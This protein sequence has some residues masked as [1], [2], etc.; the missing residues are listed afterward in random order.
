MLSKSSATTNSARFRLYSV[1]CTSMCQHC[2][3]CIR[4]AL[5]RD[6]LKHEGYQTE[7]LA[8]F[9][10]EKYGIVFFSPV[11]PIRLY[12]LRSMP[13]GIICFVF[14]TVVLAW[15]V[16]AAVIKYYTYPV[17]T[18][19]FYETAGQL[20]FPAV[21]MCNLNPL[22]EGA[23]ASAGGSMSGFKKVRLLKIILVLFLRI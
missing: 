1:W 17:K 22:R 10:A 19:M 20:E 14:I 3:S 18:Q 21:T 16:T 6:S 9:V 12:T 7:L 15:Q 4:P 11:S 23:L 13:D 8:I 2:H 5:K